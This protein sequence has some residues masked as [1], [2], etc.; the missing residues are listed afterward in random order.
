VRRAEPRQTSTRLASPAGATQEPGASDAP[1]PVRKTV[2]ARI[3]VDRAPVEASWARFADAPP[4]TMGPAVRTAMPAQLR[5]RLD[6]TAAP[7]SVDAAH[8]A[9]AIQPGDRVFLPIGVAVPRAVLAALRARADR[10]DGG[11]S[12]DEPVEL[13]TLSNYAAPETFDPAGQIVPRTLFV[14]SSTRGALADGRGG[15]VPVHLSRVPGLVR[16]G[17]I[18]V[19]VA[20][21]ATS[22]PDADGFVSV[23]PSVAAVMAAVDSARLVIAEI[24]PQIPRTR[25]ASRIHQSRI[26][27]TVQADAPLPAPKPTQPTAVD[28]AIARHVLALIPEEPTLQFG[29]GSIPDAIAAALA[30]SGRRD[31]RVHSEMISDGVRT[32]VEAGAVTGPVRYS[33]AQGS[34]ELLSWLEREPMLEVQPTERMNDPQLNARIARLIS[35]NS[36]L[37][38]DLNGQVNAQHIGGRWYS[39]VGGQVD[40]FRAAMASPGGKAILALPSTSTVDRGNGPERLSRIVPRLGDDGS[41]TTSMYDLQYVVTEHGVAALEG[42]TTEERARALIAIAAPEFRDGLLQDLDRQLAARRLRSWP[43]AVAQLVGAA[44]A[45][46]ALTRAAR[47]ACA[48]RGEPSVVDTEDFLAEPLSAALA[49][50][51][52]GESVPDAMRAPVEALGS[53]LAAGLTAANAGGSKS[54]APQLTLSRVRVERDDGGARAQGGTDGLTATLTL[55]GPALRVGRALAPRG[56]IVLARGPWVGTPVEAPGGHAPSVRLVFEFGPAPAQPSVTRA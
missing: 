19:D 32:L 14:G 26:H 54:G 39:G 11:L 3:D 23:G 56:A 27:L 55:V 46:A 6:G 45:E 44:G 16:D 35:I 47:A 7:L 42:K 12:A 1:T 18:G 5:A 52:P 48:P 33:F 2:G 36:A 34:A 15:H 49:Q 30:A 21:I 25:G 29:I 22:P 43:G 20:L 53:W 50:A 8:A 9:A 10:L 38:V 41:V 17:T 51:C 24:N 4:R 28:R 40:F 13:V 31:L 37:E